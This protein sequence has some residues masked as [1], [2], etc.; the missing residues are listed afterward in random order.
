MGLAGLGQAGCKAAGAG[1]GRLAKAIRA[2]RR[3][4][5]VACV[6]QV[7]CGFSAK[8]ILDAAEKIG[9]ATFTELVTTEPILAKPSKDCSFA[10]CFGLL[11]SV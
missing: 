5:C 9:I 7:C 2:S 11:I 1:A 4:E 3:C 6:V 8:A 10:F